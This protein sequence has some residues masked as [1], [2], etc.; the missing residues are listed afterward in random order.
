MSGDKG[1]RFHL[2]T[3]AT[4]LYLRILRGKR[5]ERMS[6]TSFSRR[7]GR[8]S[9]KRNHDR[10]ISGKHFYRREVNALQRFR[11]IFPE[12][13]DKF[14]PSAFLWTKCSAAR[15]AKM[16]NTDRVW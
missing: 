4:I 2:H 15:H 12:A 1:E 10:F 6:P 3:V 5:T 13:L 7:D 8:F 16:L 14:S 11:K 9:V